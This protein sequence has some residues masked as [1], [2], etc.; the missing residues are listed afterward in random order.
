MPIL[1][2]KYGPVSTDNVDIKEGDEV[3]VIFKY[4]PTVENFILVSTPPPIVY[5]AKILGIEKL[6]SSMFLKIDSFIRGC[7]IGK[8]YKLLDQVKYDFSFLGSAFIPKDLEIELRIG[9][10]RKL[11][12]MNTMTY[13]KE[14]KGYSWVQ[15]KPGDVITNAKGKPYSILYITDTT[16]LIQHSDQEPIL[17]RI[18]DSSA[19][20][21]FE[22]KYVQQF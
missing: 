2:H 11:I 22:L 8:V 12:N 1:T 4:S 15:A 21:A 18:S 5:E 10:S 17:I 20:K 16:L 3:E 19:M 13:C 14:T 7:A 9:P 6:S